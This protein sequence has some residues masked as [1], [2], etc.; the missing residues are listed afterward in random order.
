M[1]NQEPT[2]S[3]IRNQVLV[4]AMHRCC[5]CPEHQN[6]PNLHHVIPICE[7][8]PS[9]EENFIAVCG[10][11]HD[12]IHRFKL[13]TA[14]Q[15]RIYKKRW[16]D[17]CWLRIP[18]DIL[19][20]QALDYT[21][22]AVL[23]K[24]PPGMQPPP[25]PHFAHSYPLQE[26]F[27]GRVRERKMLTQWL[28]A[29]AR[30]V[31]ALEAIGGMGK[32]ALTWA[33]LLR[34][35]LGRCLAGLRDDLCEL[36][37]QRRVAEADRPEGVLWWSFY[38]RESSFESFVGEAL[39]YFSG[40][41][42]DPSPIAS[43]HDRMTALNQVLQARRFLVV[44]DGA[45]R[46]LRAYA[47]LDAAY[48]GDEFEADPRGDFRS[49]ADPHAGRFLQGLASDAMR[50]K[51]LLTSRHFPRE[52]DQMAGCRAEK[53]E[54][55]DPEDA[56][57]FFQAQGVTK[58]TRAEIEAA[59]GRYGYHPLCL[60]LLSGMIAEDPERPG[61]IRAADGCDPLPDLIPHESGRT[62]HVL[63]LAY[64]AL[65]PSL[66]ELLSRLA[67]FRSPMDYAAVK[68]IAALEDERDL[69]A[70][71]GELVKRGVLLFDHAQARY[72]LHPI[73]RQYA[74]D[75]LTDKE[76]VHSRLRDYFAAV[77]K[78]E[79]DK[80]QRLEDL[81]PVIELHYHTVR[82][83]RYDEAAKLFR[84]RLG[85]ILYYRFGAYQ[86]CIELL[87]ALFPDGEDQPPRLKNESDQAWT[88]NALANSYSCSGQSCRAVPLFK[89]ASVPGEKH[90]SKGTVAVSLINL[91]SEQILLGQVR[92]A[93]RNLRRCIKLFREMK[94]EFR[95]ASGHCELG[96]SLGY[97]GVFDES[98]KEL[99]I[100]EGL[101]GRLSDRRA[102]GTVW[103]SRA[104]R[105]LLQ[106]KAGAALGAA[107]R[108]RELAD[109]DARKRYPYER[110]FIEAQWLLG[111]ALV[112]QV[113]SLKFQVSR[114]E[115]GPE[116][117]NLKP[118]TSSE[119]E[120]HLTEALTR[121][122]RINLVELEPD[123]L[124]A[125]A[126]WHHLKGDTAQARAT[127]KEALAIADRCEYRLKQAD[128]H[129]F[130]A[131]LDL[132][133]GDRKSASEHARIA[134]ERA[135]CDDPPHCYKPA[136]DEARRLLDQLGVAPPSFAR[137]PAS[138]LQ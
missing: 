28:T 10:T 111:A 136:L 40:G 3:D 92:A 49:C 29:D 134:Y 15:L 20:A 69:K 115:S 127:A 80:V 64:N 81:A 17:L 34:D 14:K 46:I 126:K 82:A 70:A 88:L 99:D 55:F 58:G 83:G 32:S 38:E 90:G 67:A 19:M 66:R 35:V 113:E 125:W 9:S 77:P 86:T 56:V 30:P 129:N 73:V 24:M 27:T 23:P 94:D 110:D 121:C 60:R 107:R 100:A 106:G 11:C 101:F 84:D 51:V 85:D 117:L 72:D 36:A 116:T 124:L 128:I 42:I 50:S 119:A 130:L 102:Q 2:L 87:R 47:S 105:E 65:R 137:T 13:Y 31:M 114:S 138:P 26:N 98:A 89:T 112:A 123:I 8:G 104:L 61:D 16:V 93:E 41:T 5:L 22:P 131:R 4:D 7:G 25:E 97:R 132:D 37:P 71:L 103:T 74:Y 122:R 18:Q 52:L 53:L 133:A 45:E 43:L 108:A 63:E 96:R 54:A 78:I 44:L 68:A 109:E 76:G 1:E 48:R 62:H 21:K 95:E 135:W 39:T 12:K 59:C 33:W 91:G 57:T 79:K 75:R 118:E 6:V 120:S